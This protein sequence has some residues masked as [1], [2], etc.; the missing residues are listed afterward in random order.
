MFGMGRDVVF[1]VIGGGELRLLSNG[2][3]VLAVLDDSAI[4]F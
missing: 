2:A 1:S 3:E 4:L